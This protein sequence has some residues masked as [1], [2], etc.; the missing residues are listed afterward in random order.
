MKIK[1]SFV[2]R[3]IADVWTV[4]PLADDTLN[5]DGMITMNES[6]VLL[7]NRLAEGCSLADLVNTLTET[8]DVAADEAAADAA[9]FVDKLRSCGCLEE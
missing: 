3:K 6:G 8:Y 9:S 1:S 5:F 2:L 4:L 7:W